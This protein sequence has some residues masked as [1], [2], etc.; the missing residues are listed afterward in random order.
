MLF[1]LGL[2]HKED[3]YLIRAEENKA[4]SLELRQNLSKIP[5]DRRIA[6]G[7]YL[8][9]DLADVMELYDIDH[10]PSIRFGRDID[11]LLI[12]TRHADLWSQ[13]VAA[14]YKDKGFV[15]SEDL[16]GKSLA[17]FVLDKGSRLTE[18]ESSEGDAAESQSSETKSAR[19]DATE[20]DTTKN[21]ASESKASGSD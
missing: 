15:Y 18:D 9:Y 2:L 8:C 3:P 1:S 21:D 5:R 4:Q 19:R 16:S 7:Q 11:L 10:N 17:A 14:W 13:S 20:S 6:A 12:D